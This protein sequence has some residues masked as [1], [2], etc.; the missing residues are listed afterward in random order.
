LGAV[1]VPPLVL[2]GVVGAAILGATGPAPAPAQPTPRAAL[3][4]TASPPARL[5]SVPV[6][7]PIVALGLPV[8]DVASALDGAGREDTVLAVRGYLEM[9]PRSRDCIVDAIESRSFATFAKEQGFVSSA[10]T[11]C[12]RHAS[13]R[14]WAT[15]VGPG[16]TPRL[17]VTVAIGAVVPVLPVAE[18][19]GQSVPAVLVG[20][21]SGAANACGAIH[22]CERHFDAD[23]LV[24][25]DGLWRGPTTSV[26]PA[27][28]GP[29]LASRVRD[30]LAAEVTAPSDVLLLETLVRPATLRRVDP[31]AA[32][33]LGASGDSRPIWY[34]RLL[35]TTSS[36]AATVHWVTIDD[37]S[38]RLLASG[39]VSP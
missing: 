36:P 3:A 18:P 26:E 8:V 16:R 37:A 30:R 34:R 25:V 23:R 17:D 1:A 15:T 20:R 27:L 5:G 29:R 33:D 28:A 14:P 2:A 39:L 35:D 32:R 24:W 9:A 4:P 10:T 7:F 21:L 22:G 19:P 12:D 11:F 31:V 6:E 38:G 13:L